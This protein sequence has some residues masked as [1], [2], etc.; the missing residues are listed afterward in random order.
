[1]G[2][3]SRQP[4]PTGGEWTQAKSRLTNWTR[5]GGTDNA[6]AHAALAAFVGALG[7]AA[8]AAAGA[9]GGVRST[10]G[11][12]EF[13]TDI[14]RDG[15]EETLDRYGLDDLVGG[16]PVE[17]LG[18]LATRISGAGNSPEEAVARDA[19]LQVLTEAFDDPDTFESMAAIAI[20]EPLLIELLARY[21]TEYLFLR[22]LHELGDRIRDNAS[23][24]DAEKLERR[25]RDDLR[26]LVNLDLSTIDHPLDFEWSSAAGRARVEELVREAFRMM[27]A[28]E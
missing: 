28:G 2:T 3:S 18:E 24:T 25:L 16:D 13:L 17:V 4:S 22:V 11:L 27:S 15:L 20:D 12:G 8:A 14:S 1:M 26:A 19:L 21:V 5:N 23:P 7:G 6:V 10:A 9:T